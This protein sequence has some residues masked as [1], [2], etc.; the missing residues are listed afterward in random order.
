MRWEV[1]SE[2]GFFERNDVVR[3]ARDYNGCR[4]GTI[5]KIAHPLGQILG[6]PSGRRYTM[7]TVVVLQPRGLEGIRSPIPELQ[8]F[9]VPEE[10]LERMDPA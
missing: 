3:F 7:V 1:V 4:A 5:A 8:I 2:R 9:S 6:D 10:V